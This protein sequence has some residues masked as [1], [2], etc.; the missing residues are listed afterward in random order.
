MKTFS[1]KKTSEIKTDFELPFALFDEVN[2]VTQE[3]E[4]IIDI[5]DEESIINE[6]E[7]IVPDSDKTIIEVIEPK[8]QTMGAT[9]DEPEIHEPEIDYDSIDISE[10]SIDQLLQLKV[11]KFNINNVTIKHLGY[12]TIDD[13][14]VTEYD[15]IDNETN[16]VLLIINVRLKQVRFQIPKHKSE[17][18]Q[19]TKSKKSKK[20]EQTPLEQLAREIQKDLKYSWSD[21]F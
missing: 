6:P 9:K 11:N 5:H 20:K 19:K 10:L 4:Q 17:P 12:N 14:V 2:E 15:L 18:E 13:Y 16:N 7:Q 1:T 8:T 21:W 3:K